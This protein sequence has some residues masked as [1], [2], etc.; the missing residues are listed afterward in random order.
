MERANK[1]RIKMKNTMKN[2]MKT[3][4]WNFNFLDSYSFEK[5]IERSVPDYLFT[6]NLIIQLSHFFLFENSTIVDIGSTTGNLITKI[7]NETSKEKLKF[8]AIEP[9]IKMVNVFKKNIKKKKLKNIKIINKSFE[10]C[11]IPKSDLII[12]HYT[13]QFIKPSERQNAF[14]KIYKS[15]HTGGAFIF[16]EKIIG[17]NSRFENIFNSLLIDYKITNKFTSDEIL[18]KSKSLRGVM[19]PCKDIEN[20]KFLK[21]TG[22]SK[23][24]T[25]HQKINFKGYLCIK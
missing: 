1:H 21:K 20:I 10:K 23:I 17:N 7:I 16:F 13:I 12:S 25:I 11:K 15:L 9:E 19:D 3:G 24:Q 6:H 14:N 2:K 18:N 22:F 4:S 5:H 8:I